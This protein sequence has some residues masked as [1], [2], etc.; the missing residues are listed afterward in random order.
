MK[1]LILDNYDSFTFNLFQYIAGISAPPVVWRNDAVTLDEIASQHFDRIIIS[2]GPGNPED[3]RYFGVCRAAIL[4]L[5]YRIPIL[6]VCLGHQ[7]IISAFGGVIRRAAVPMHGKTS[8]IGHDGRGV[9]SGIAPS[10]EVMRY[11]S[12]V[13]ELNSLPECLE[14]AAT[15]AEGELMAVRHRSW[16]IH[17]VQFHPESIGTTTGKAILRNFMSPLCSAPGQKSA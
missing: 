17:G 8:R 7:G 6:G 5:G 16:P 10:V 12:L 9:F 1:T 2:P 15:T 3:P 13:G 4:E 11:H 14:V